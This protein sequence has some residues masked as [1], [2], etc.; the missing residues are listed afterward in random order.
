[1]PFDSSTAVAEG[2]DASTAQP[3]SSP[4]SFDA[5]TA[6][7]ETSEASQASVDA[8][9]PPDVQAELDTIGAPT[10][11]SEIPAKATESPG[12]WQT[13]NTSLPEAAR[14]VQDSVTKAYPESADVTEGLVGKALDFA[15]KQP[16]VFGLL[17]YATG[18]DSGTKIGV[19]INK[20]VR[21][22]AEGLLS[23]LGISTLGLGAAPKVVQ[24]MAG[25]AFATHMAKNLPDTVASIADAKTPEEM[26]QRVTEAVG[27]AAMLLGIGRGLAGRPSTGGILPEQRSP[28]T[29]VEVENM[30]QAAVASGEATPAPELKRVTTV[31]TTGET[32]SPEVEAQQM[33]ANMGA[34]TEQP[35]IGNKTQPLER[36]SVAV[37]VT[38]EWATATETAEPVIG[39][40]TEMKKPSGEKGSISSPAIPTRKMSELDVATA[41][42]SAKLQKSFDEAQRAQKEIKK[43]IPDKE[44]QQAAS[45]YREADGD[46]ALLQTW[47]ANAKQDWMRDAA[48]TAQTLTPE[49][50]G[51]VDKSKA[52][53][54]VLEKRGNAYGVLGSHR[55]NYVPHVWDVGPNKGLTGSRRLQERFKFNKARTFDTFFD[56]DQAGFK[57]KSFAIGEVLPTYIAEMNKVIADRQF[58]KDLSQGKTDT[59]EPLAVPL[60]RVVT[61]PESGPKE[62]V[63]VMPTASRS[64]DT[65]NYEVVPNQPALN[66]WTW[67]GKDT[68]GNPVFVK[69]ELALHPKAVK[70]INA[71]LGKSHIRKLVEN[72]EGAAQIPAAIVKGLDTAQSVMKREMFGLLAPFHQ[73]QEGTHAI[74]HT[75]NPFFG[76]PKIDLRDSA[77]MDAARHGLMLLPDRATSSLYMEGSG[78]K[79][80]FISQATRWVGQKSKVRAVEAVA[81]VIDG[82]QDYLFHQYIPGLKF[83]TYESI[84][85]RN[86]SLYESELKSGKL[87]ERD[88]KLLS[89]EQANAAYGHLNYD[90]L[91]RDPTVKHVMQLALLAPDFLE[92]RGKFAAQAAKTLTGSKAG[93][94]QFRAIAL[95]ATVQIGTAYTLAKLLGGE[96]DAKHPFELVYKNRRYAMR[97]V[98]EDI[99]S[100]FDDPRKFSMARVSPLITKGGIQAMT[101]LNYR[102]EKVEFW[103][104]TVPELLSQYIPITARSLPGLRE[105]N[106]TTRDNPT[107]PIEQYAGSLGL[108]ISRYSP[109]SDTYKLAGEWM[110]KQNIPRDKGSYPVSKYSKLR[111]ALEDSDEDRALEHY[112]KLRE[113]MKPA[114]IAKG[115]RE[116]T[117]HPFTQ[118]KAMDAKFR[119][120]LKD[121][122]R[123]L[124]DLARIRRLEVLQRFGKMPK[125][126]TPAPSP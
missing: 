80:G 18:D 45:I 75:V 17:D 53:F 66:E 112:L 108:R 33:L 94:E 29:D 35:I 52:A 34:R 98:P 115:F 84:L 2:F 82:Y 101:G 72:A 122:D 119:A 13:I 96:W 36:E 70:R 27:S 57:P 47:E 121:A 51:I 117:L 28:S 64:I 69:A 111:Y 3:E 73:V 86:R 32:P 58:V 116:S 123:A 88:I 103:K 83:K 22:L 56:G 40:A 63:L 54:D 76:I 7:P 20:G 120:S 85:E 6:Q 12:V 78:S 26:A 77:Q 16:G 9:I 68:D 8:N 109:I 95:M 100:L 118:S 10:T 41:E 60:G 50:V 11:P 92:A 104:D 107:S 90:L 55:E 59:G 15:E 30:E 62:S 48:K 79:S 23:P 126:Q 102:G 61:V 14:S 4:V 5:S 46:M 38:S 105:L 71:M 124:L 21:H 65:S 89:A 110:D 49:E 31:T 125:S 25:Y 44:R 42:R 37:P 39:E 81:D 87:Q 114:D 43:V 113:T 106:K 91:D 93:V 97:S 24:Q 67:E 99:A 19:G 1:M 74:G